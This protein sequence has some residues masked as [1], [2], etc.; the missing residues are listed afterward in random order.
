[1]ALNLF[2]A[3]KQKKLNLLFSWKKGKK[4]PKKKREEEIQ[5]T[6]IFLTYKRFANKG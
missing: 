4:K 3:V 2:N 6:T 1:M 5:Y